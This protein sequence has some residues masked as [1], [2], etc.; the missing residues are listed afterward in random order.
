MI[1]INNVQRFTCVLK[2]IA[3]GRGEVYLTP[4]NYEK[5]MGFTKVSNNMETHR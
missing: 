5:Y 4:L 3:N 2:Q 1:L